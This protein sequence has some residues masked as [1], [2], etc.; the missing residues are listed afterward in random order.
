MLEHVTRRRLPLPESGVEIALLDWGG[1]GPLAL[2]HHANGFCAAMWDLV[3]RPLTKHFR[4]IGMDARGHG[5]SSSPEGAGFYRWASFAGDLTAVVDALAAEHPDGRVTLGLGH[6][7]GGAAML[8]AS[9]ER[10][11]LFGKLVLVDPVLPEPAL[12]EERVRRIGD[13][14]ERAL[15]RR[16]LFDAREDARASWEGK[17]FFTGWLPDAFDLYLAEGLRDRPDGRVELKCDPA[18]EAAIFE[19]GPGT[20]I[21]QVASRV[22]VPTLL[23][24]AVRGDFPRLA[25]ETVASGMAQG[26]IRDIES[27]HLAPM[28]RPDLV[29]DEVLDFTGVRQDSVG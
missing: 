20:D 5:D 9:A 19:A 27:G 29:V 21:W 15:K 22:K 7:F 18:V 23:L 16:R 14:V 11:D 2:L 3:A 1:E 25:Y 17:D 6:S 4:V 13:L 12:T 8:L 26:Q 24:W 28:E 10:P